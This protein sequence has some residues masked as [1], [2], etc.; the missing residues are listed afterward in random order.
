MAMVEDA[1]QVAL[2]AGNSSEIIFRNYMEM[3]T[4]TQAGSW[5]RIEPEA[6]GKVISINSAN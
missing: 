2:K 6:K 1:S 3:V 4:R 5:F